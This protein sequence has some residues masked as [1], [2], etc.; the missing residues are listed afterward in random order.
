MR[1]LCHEEFYRDENDE[2]LK[3]LHVNL[4]LYLL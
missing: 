2:V 4:T 3:A 1:Q